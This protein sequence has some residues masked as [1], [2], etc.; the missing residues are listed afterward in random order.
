MLLIQHHNDI[1]NLFAKLYLWTPFK[2]H[3]CVDQWQMACLTYQV[4][5]WRCFALHMNPLRWRHNGCDSVS[6]HQ[7]RECLLRCLIRRTSK[8]TSKLR[9]TGLWAG[10]SPETGEFPAQMASNAENASIWWRHHANFQSLVESLQSSF[11]IC[12]SVTKEMVVGVRVI[13]S[14]GER[15]VGYYGIKA[16]GVTL[17]THW[18]RV[19]HICV[20]KLYHHWFR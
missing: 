1:H 10:N 4:K 19:T 3:L 12:V 13:C 18:G 8:K 14:P 15:P 16:T 6:N 17:L 5:K 9:V 2:V 11:I 7:P 20:S